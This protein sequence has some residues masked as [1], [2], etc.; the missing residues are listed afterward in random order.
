MMFHL[1]VSEEME[2]IPEDITVIQDYG[3]VSLV[4][5]GFPLEMY[6]SGKH[7][8]VE[9]SE[10]DVRAWLG[11]FDG[12]WIGDGPPMLQKFQIMHVSNP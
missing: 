3:E 9:G 2:P 7:M 1:L 8:V 12:V 11:S 10:D 5:D 6:R 4:S